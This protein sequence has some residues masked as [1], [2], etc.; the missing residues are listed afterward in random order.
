MGPHG[1]PG[2]MKAYAWIFCRPDPPDCFGHLRIYFHTPV[3]TCRERVFFTTCCGFVC[4]DL[5]N[6]WAGERLLRVFDGGHNGV[7]PSWRSQRNS[8]RTS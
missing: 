8:K 7:R 3:T 4:Q 2:T 6:A 1:P 5:H